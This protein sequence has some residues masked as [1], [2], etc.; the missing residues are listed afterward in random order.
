MAKWIT[1]LLD[2]KK[3][4]L[5]AI[6]VGIVAALNAAGLIDEATA[7]MFYG[8]LGAGGLACLRSGIEKK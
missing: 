3:T 8:F 1:D 5:V 6:G 7:K 4:Y 2:G